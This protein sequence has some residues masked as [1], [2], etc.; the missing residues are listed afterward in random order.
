MRNKCIPIHFAKRIWKSSKFLYPCIYS[1]LGS[2]IFLEIIILIDILYLLQN[3]NQ[4]IINQMI[5]IFS[6][7]YLLVFLALYVGIHITD[8]WML[9]ERYNQINYVQHCLL[10]VFSRKNCQR[11]LWVF[12]MNNVTLTTFVDH[13]PIPTLCGR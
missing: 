6:H 11:V 7:I 12:K 1:F 4:C 3:Q 13:I 9:P 2:W 10:Y 5:L 8:L